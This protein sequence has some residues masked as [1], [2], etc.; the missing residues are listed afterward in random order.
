VCCEFIPNPSEDKNPQSISPQ[1]E[2]ARNAD[3]QAFI[4]I[5]ETRTLEVAQKPEV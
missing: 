4:V 3:S 2:L 5:T 1:Q